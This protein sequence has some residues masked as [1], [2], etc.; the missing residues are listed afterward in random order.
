MW[1]YFLPGGYGAVYFH[2][3]RHDPLECDSGGRRIGVR[4]CSVPSPHHST[5]FAGEGEVS[6]HKSLHILS[7]CR[8]PPSPVLLQRR[9]NGSSQTFESPLIPPRFLPCR[10][11]LISN[12]PRP[13]LYP[14]VVARCPF[15]RLRNGT[16]QLSKD[17]FC[18]RP[19][20]TTGWS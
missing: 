14:L 5:C 2:A 4:H 16:P 18:P 19:C 7:R 8:I 1:G 15:V 13:Q 9:P 6:A 12:S 20:L 17:L 11:S 3:L 10:D